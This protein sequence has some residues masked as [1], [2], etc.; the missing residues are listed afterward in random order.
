MDPTCD[1]NWGTCY[2]YNSYM[3]YLMYYHHEGKSV[4]V[5][6]T[7][8]KNTSVELLPSASWGKIYIRTGKD[9]SVAIYDIN[10]KSIQY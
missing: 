1:S 6:E 5:N 9:V 7:N 2:N 4:G 3:Q 10:G 8:T